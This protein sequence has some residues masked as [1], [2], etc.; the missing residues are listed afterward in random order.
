MDEFF[1]RLDKCF[2]D[3]LAKRNKEAKRRAKKEAE[4]A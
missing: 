2:K 1:A 4:A 3:F